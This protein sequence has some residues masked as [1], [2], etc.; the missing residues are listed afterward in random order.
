[1]HAQRPEFEV[2]TVKMSPAVPFGTPI[3]INLGTFRN[4]S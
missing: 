3:G 4:G 1:V 2:A